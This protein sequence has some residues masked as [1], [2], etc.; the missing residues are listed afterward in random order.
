MYIEQ[1]LANHD[2]WFEVIRH[3]RTYT[4]QTTARALHIRSQE[5]AKSVLVKV[6]SGIVLAVVPGNASLNL[7]ALNQRLKGHSVSLL[8]E[9]EMIA[10]FPDCE[11]G[12]L[13]PFGSQYGMTTVVDEGLAR[14]PEI[15]FEGNTHSEA[16]RM[17]YED[18]ARIEQ[19]LVGQIALQSEPVGP[20][21]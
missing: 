5:V 7:T 1:F 8:P 3:D 12:A 13:P 2:V 17:R 16:I 18:Y 20:G 15:V 4:A 6:D 19:P 11:V 10:R 21:E 9:S 14:E